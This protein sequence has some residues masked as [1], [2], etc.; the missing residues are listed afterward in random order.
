MRV[1]WNW[2]AST[3]KQNSENNEERKEEEE[4]RLLYRQTGVCCSLPFATPLPEG[5]TVGAVKAHVVLAVRRGG[6]KHRS[7]LARR[8]KALVGENHVGEVRMS[9]GLLCRD[10]L[11]GVVPQ[12]LLHNT[13]THTHQ[14]RVRSGKVH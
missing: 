8:L 10:S 7:K 11:V 13:H 5:G 6:K 12:H 2:V 14:S 9:H 3:P 4:E 1:I